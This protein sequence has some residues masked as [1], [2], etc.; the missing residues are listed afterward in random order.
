MHL[1]KYEYIYLCVCRAADAV[2]ELQHRLA[3]QEERHAVAIA[4]MEVRMRTEMLQQQQVN[5]IR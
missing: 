3:M 1:Y 5:G 2:Q 4:E